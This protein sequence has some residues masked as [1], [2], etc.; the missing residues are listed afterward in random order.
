MPLDLNVVCHFIRNLDFE[1]PFYGRYLVFGFVS[2]VAALNL[3]HLG[4]E[5]IREERL[6]F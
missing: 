6:D 1:I 4:I 2:W 3:L 5:E